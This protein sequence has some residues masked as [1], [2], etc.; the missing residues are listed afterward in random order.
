[1]GGRNNIGCEP[2]ETAVES[3]VLR[4]CKL[5]GNRFLF[6]TMPG[7]LFDWFRRSI[8][9]RDH[10]CHLATNVDEALFFAAGCVRTIVDDSDCC[11]LSAAGAL[12]C[13]ACSGNRYIEI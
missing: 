8:C 6:V 10:L 13:L 2:N 5:L 7:V 3:M 12:H 9:G 1:M 11:I 4:L